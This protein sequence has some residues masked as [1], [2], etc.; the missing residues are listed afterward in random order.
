M[1]IVGR[2]LI[3]LAG[4][5]AT[6][7][8]AVVGCST[9]NNLNSGGGTSNLGETCTR[10][11]DCM[12]GLICEQNV[13]LKS[14]TPPVPDGGTA[15]GGDSGTSMP[16]PHL[17]L[18]NES[19]QVSSDCQSPLE[20]L[21]QV[22]NIV[23]WGLT[24]TGKSCSGECNTAADC[25]ELPFNF[26]PFLSG[27][28]TLTDGGGYIFHP[29]LS[30]A[31]TRCE[32]L[33]AFLGGDATICA[34][35]A[36]FTTLT[37]SLAEGCFDY[38]TYCGS[39]GTSGPW[40]CTN[41]QCVYT[42]PCTPSGPPAAPA[43]ACPSETRTGRGLS[44]TCTVAAGATTGSCQ[45]GCAVDSDCAGK[46]PS[47]STHTCSAAD[48]GAGTNCTCYQSACYFKCAQDLDCVSSDTCDTTTH[49]CKP[50]GCKMDSDCIQS[51][52]K[53]RGK[54]VMSQCE[55]AC[56]NDSNCDPPLTICSQ[57]YCKTSGCTSDSDCPSSGPHAFCVTATPTTYT[58]AI[59]N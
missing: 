29:G 51:L 23:S 52:D 59:T 27:W 30:Q 11:F 3:S 31:N 8:V 28:D 56:D 46:V 19:C 54:C 1:K 14:A 43:T 24:A 18:L 2:I 44:T 40:A 20:C 58:G 12:T 22:C 33:L 16:G 17:G 25:C 15:S 35:T 45:A 42:A 32:D 39:C 7:G 9:T 57:G 6:A 37:Q 13:C 55:L 34:N 38:N 53:A 36:N 41:N 21:G 10:T 50:A 49:L 4:A 26:S 48:A 5:L 47:G